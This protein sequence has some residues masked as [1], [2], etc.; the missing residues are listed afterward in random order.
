MVITLLTLL[1]CQNDLVCIYIHKVLNSSN[2][3]IGQVSG[4]YYYTGIKELINGLRYRVI[5]VIDLAKGFTH[6]KQLD[7]YNR[8][9]P[10]IHM[11]FYYLVSL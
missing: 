3:K 8:V 1:K 11:R 9:S 10:T 4:N 2:T 5:Q 7:P 6:T